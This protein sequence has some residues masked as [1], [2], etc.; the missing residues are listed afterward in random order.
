MDFTFVLTGRGWYAASCPQGDALGYG[1]HWAFSP[2][3]LV[4]P[5]PSWIRNSSVSSVDK[6]LEISV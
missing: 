5:R 3:L 6:N 4:I 2:L 1:S